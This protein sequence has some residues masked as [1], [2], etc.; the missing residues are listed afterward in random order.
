M[1]QFLYRTLDIL[2]Q[3]QFDPHTKYNKHSYSLSVCTTTQ[4]DII[5][6]SLFLSSW[7]QLPSLLFLFLLAL[8]TISFSPLFIFPQSNI[9]FSHTSSPNLLSIFSSVPSTL[10]LFLLSLPSTS[11]SWFFIFPLSNILFS[12][13]SSPNLFLIISSMSF[14]LHCCS[15]SSSSSIVSWIS[16][17]YDLEPTYKLTIYYAEDMPY[18]LL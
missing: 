11:F 18:L 12:Q 3:I 15:S 14:L 17:Q 5:I 9:L 1:L 6:T 2:W 16:S 10:F 13:I 4:S 8:F 7:P